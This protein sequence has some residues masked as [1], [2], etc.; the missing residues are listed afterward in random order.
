MQND[1]TI[2][3]QPLKPSCK[4]ETGKYF[5]QDFPVK[6]NQTRVGRKLFL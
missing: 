3:I 2:I 4:K 6:R 1:Y 5:E